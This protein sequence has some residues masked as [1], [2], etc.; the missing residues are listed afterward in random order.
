MEERKFSRVMVICPVSGLLGHSDFGAWG[1]TQR[2]RG[3]GRDWK[4]EVRHPGS[5]NFRTSGIASVQKAELFKNVP[6][7]LPWWSHG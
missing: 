3:L 2:L 7:G 6:W 4:L 5:L 1:G